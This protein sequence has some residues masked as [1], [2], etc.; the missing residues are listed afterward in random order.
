MAM[1]WLCTLVLMTG[2][3]DHTSPFGIET[4]ETTSIHIHRVCAHAMRAGTEVFASFVFDDGKAPDGPYANCVELP[5]SATAPT[6]TV[7]AGGL[8]RQRIAHRG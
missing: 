4:Q 7:S 6:V 2:C 1:K 8:T 3:L 5:F